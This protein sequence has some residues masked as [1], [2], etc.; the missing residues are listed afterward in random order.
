[1]AGRSA[2]LCWRRSMAGLKRSENAQ[3][4]FRS[5]R[6][7]PT[8]EIVMD[9]V[10][11]F[12][13]EGAVAERRRIEGAVWM[14]HCAGARY[15]ISWGAMGAAELCWHAAPPMRSSIASSL[16]GRLS[17]PALPEEARRYCRLRLRSSCGHSARGPSHGRRAEEPRTG[18][19]SSLKRNN[20]G[21]ALRDC[22]PGSAICMVLAESPRTITS[23]G[24]CL[25]LVDRE[26]L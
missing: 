20:C 17:K 4:S 10:E 9:G 24:A 16:G 2:A 22:P 12:G 26:Y 15:G 25:N 14:P 19:F 7:L 11:K 5:G 8:G 23:C 21:K 6:R 13:D 1:M 18:C 3:A